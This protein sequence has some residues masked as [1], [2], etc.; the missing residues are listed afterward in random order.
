MM[1]TA[2]ILLF[3][4]TGIFA[5]GKGGAAGQRLLDEALAIQSRPA[6]GESE[7]AA[8]D[9]AFLKMG[10]ALQADPN[11]SDAYFYRGF[12]RCLKNGIVRA[13]LGERLNDMR[14]QGYSAAEQ[15]NT[16]A[17]GE[18]FIKAVLHDAYENFARMAL[19]MKKQG[20]WDEDV[21]TFT[22]GA[23][24]FASAEYLRAK[25]DTPG[26]IDEFRSLMKRNW[27]PPLCADLIA[28]SYLQL[29]AIAFADEDFSGAQE[30]WDKG[31]RWAAAPH[32]RRTLLTNKAGAYEMDN[33]FGLAEEL[34]R[35]QIKSEP[36]RPTHWKN[37]GLVLGYQS[38]L[39]SALYA[40]G[41]SRRQCRVLGTRFPVALLHGNSWLKAA[42]IHGKL[43]EADG[44]LRIAWRLFLEYRGMF[45]DD[46][47]FCINFGEF[48]HQMGQ[49]ELAWTFLVRAREIHPFCPNPYQLLL[50]VAQRMATGT[51][52]ERKARREKAKAEL[53]RIRELFKSRDESQALTRLCGGLRDLGDGRSQAI[54]AALI[55]PDPLRGETAGNPPLWI[56]DAAA[57]REP[58]V[59][60]EPSIEEF[61]AESAQAAEA[62]AEAQEPAAPPETDAEAEPGIAWRKWAVGGVVALV[63]LGLC[64]LLLRR[65]PA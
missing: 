53:Q 22:R 28:R 35:K 2:L 24:K 59:P 31:L 49:Y 4:A 15:Q 17:H 39:R 63:L 65:K 64:G 55:Q 30:F 6:P 62:A 61:L 27:N 20:T 50:P 26:A 25:G 48:C 36:D 40:Y 57:R 33:Q 12:N 3:A 41:Q 46:Y 34:L 51:P 14:A 37:L 32:I 9:R 45:G 52:E 44:D 1:R 19:I 21:L 11:L 16:R 43:L 38:H 8:L 42:M 13:I 58:Y 18:Q 5:Q 47:N 56:V 60:Y 54:R 29:G 7:E 23:T 10:E